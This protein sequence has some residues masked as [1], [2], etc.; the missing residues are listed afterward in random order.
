[1]LK[2]DTVLPGVLFVRTDCYVVIWYRARPV[3]DDASS[4]RSI[5]SREPV[6]LPLCNRESVDG[7]WQCFWLS[8]Q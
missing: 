1:M 7:R 4:S 6:A 2:I 5:C 8:R 3:C